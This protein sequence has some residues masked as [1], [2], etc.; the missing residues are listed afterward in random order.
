M[1][2]EVVNQAM[3]LQ[4]DT[5]DAWHHQPIEIQ[6]AVSNLL[7]SPS[8]C[9]DSVASL[10]E[11]HPLMSD[12]AWLETICKQHSFN[13]QLWH[14]EDIA[15]SPVVTDAEMATVKRAIDGFNQNRNDWIE[16]IDDLLTNHIQIENIQ[17]AN[18]ARLNTE[19][20]G[21]AFDRLS[22][23]SL[24]LYHLQEQL[25]RDDATAEHKVKVN[26]KIAICRLQQKDLSQSLAQLLT[27]ILAG[28]K[29]HATY[30]Q[31]KMY[32]DPSLNPEVYN[33]AHSERSRKQHTKAA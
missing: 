4:C 3:Q 18:D 25:D 13:F 19:T 1:S 20:P 12:R 5:V 6:T 26:Q 2:M 15:R 11:H 23:M 21:S 31:C 17:V 22:I 28:T 9:C 8:T 33:A 32:N 27:D 14:Q 16:K 24:R 10:P 7:A 30:R 29:R